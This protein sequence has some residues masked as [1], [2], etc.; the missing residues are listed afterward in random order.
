MVEDFPVGDSLHLIDLGVMK[1]CL[2]GWRDGKIGSYSTKWCSR[3]INI[4]STFLKKCKMPLEIHRAV[5]GLDTLAFWKGTEY[6]T[7]LLYISIV[8][9]KKVLSSD[10]YQ[11]FLLLFCARTICS[12]E[13][14]THFLPL[15]DSMFRNYVELYRDFYGEDYMTSN[16][17]N[18]L[19]LTDEVKKI[20]VLSTFNAYPFESRLFYIKKT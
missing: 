16:I 5:R 8:I 11:H 18:I 10:I 7:F 17:H 6:R 12:T 15:A 3:D 13:M 19:H 20:G 14:F 2:T 9:L 4:V 1:R